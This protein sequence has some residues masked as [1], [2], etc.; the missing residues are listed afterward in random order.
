MP[1]EHENDIMRQGEV[2]F[3]HMDKNII[4]AHIGVGVLHSITIFFDQ[5]IIP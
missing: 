4:K 2:V 3:D 5:A 1:F